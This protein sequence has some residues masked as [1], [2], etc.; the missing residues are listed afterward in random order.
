MCL[1]PVPGEYVLTTSKHLLGTFNTVLY[2]AEIWY[3]CS[4]NALDVNRG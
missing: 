2:Y 3:V 1:L 4:Q